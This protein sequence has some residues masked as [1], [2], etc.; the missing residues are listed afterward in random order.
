MIE[1][2]IVL[3]SLLGSE[4]SGKMTVALRAVAE[5][6]KGVSVKNEKTYKKIF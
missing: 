4:S 1:R 5:A 6:Q 2:K 3:Q